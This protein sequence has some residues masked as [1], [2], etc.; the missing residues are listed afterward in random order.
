MAAVPQLM[1]PLVVPPLPGVQYLGKTGYTEGP[2]QAHLLSQCLLLAWVLF[3]SPFSL[4][5]A[6]SCLPCNG[7]AV[8]T[9]PQHI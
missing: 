9:V 5:K 2:T 7:G 1:R 6:S 4:C 3:I 8:F